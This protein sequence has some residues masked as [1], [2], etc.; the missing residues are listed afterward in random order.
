MDEY[1]SKELCLNWLAGSYC[2][3]KL[4]SIQISRFGVIPKQHQQNS[5]RLII[6]LSHPKT[7]SVNDS[8]P[9]IL[10][11]L[12]YITIDDVILRIVQLGSNA[13][14]AK[15]DI[16]SAFHLLPV[17]PADRHLLGNEWHN[18]IYLDTCL[19][20]RLH[21]A[22]KLFNILW[23]GQSLKGVRQRAYIT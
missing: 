21:S 12:S 5:W 8:I 17:H 22:P 7:N 19:P 11:G 20:F 1:L 3:S 10:C 9:K 13:L 2:K 16:K 15:L 6:D 14:L 4:P 23:S 18:S